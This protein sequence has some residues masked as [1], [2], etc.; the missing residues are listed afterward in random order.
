MNNSMSN[1][2]QNNL[3]RLHT[4]ELGFNRIRKKL[5]LDI[6]D[7]VDWCKQKVL[8]AGDIFRQG[9]NWYVNCDN[10][11]I[12]INA[13]SYTIITAHKRKHTK[14]LDE[15]KLGNLPSDFCRQVAGKNRRNAMC[16][17]RF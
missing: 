1:E 2:L 8:T 4:T 10:C 14:E 6:S 15:N 17:S 12:T 3:D 7:I 11:V 5:D 16:I 9:K 13:R